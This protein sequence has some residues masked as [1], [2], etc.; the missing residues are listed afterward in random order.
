MEDHSGPVLHSRMCDQGEETR[1]GQ[2]AR[3]ALSLSL[4]QHW[5][6]SAV[7]GLRWWAL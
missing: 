6:W 3:T 2:C 5:E 4:S 1:C 7:L